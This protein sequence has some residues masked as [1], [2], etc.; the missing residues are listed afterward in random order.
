MFGGLVPIDAVRSFDLPQGVNEC[1]YRQCAQRTLRA[2]N[3]PGSGFWADDGQTGICTSQ[4]RRRSGAN[5]ESLGWERLEEIAR[6]R[7]L[8]L[9]RQETAPRLLP[10]ELRRNMKQLSAAVAHV[11][12]RPRCVEV[13]EDRL[14]V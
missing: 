7:R 14:I 10:P 4:I 6:L 2:Q 3:F 1:I 5:C 13:G 8:L 11:C 12:A 9:A